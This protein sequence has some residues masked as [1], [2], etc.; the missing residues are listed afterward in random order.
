MIF[1]PLSLSIAFMSRFMFTN[2]LL[3]VAPKKNV[4]IADTLNTIFTFNPKD[5]TNI[6][7]SK[8]YIQVRFIMQTNMFLS[9]ILTYF[10]GNM[11]ETN[12]SGMCFA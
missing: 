2:K 8:K 10:P 5:A 3:N 4:I 12:C 11:K 7:K 9:R 6:K 1:F